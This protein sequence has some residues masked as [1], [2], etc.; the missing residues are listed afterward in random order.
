MQS[1]LVS[2]CMP[3]YNGARFLELAIQSVLSQTYSNL[4][5]IIHDDAST[6]G[7]WEIARNIQDPRVILYRN[8]CNSGPEANWNSVVSRARGKYIKLFHQDDILAKNCLDRQVRV[9]EDHPASVLAFCRRLIIR[10]DGHRLATRGCPWGDGPVLGE[11]ILNR[12]IRFGTNLVG[13]PSAVL[14]RAESARLA[15]PFDGSIPYLIDLDY[16]AKLLIHGNGYYIDEPL[17]AF[18]ISRSQWSAAI[19]LRQGKDFNL[20]LDRLM[21]GGYPCGSKW[22]ILLGRLSAHGNGLLRILV[23]RFLTGGR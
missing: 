6:D 13:E 10:A 18:R 19:G 11:R 23:H 4:E 22:A 5:L 7:S 20:F 9:L 15:G 12:C 17:V 2:V 3:V 21:D 1:P 8:S 16:W 14:F